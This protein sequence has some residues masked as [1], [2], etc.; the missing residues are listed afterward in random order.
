MN[1][2]T[3]V[4]L[5]EEGL[6]LLEYFKKWITPVLETISDFGLLELTGDTMDQGV[7]ITSV[8]KDAGINSVRL[9]INIRT[10]TL[11]LELQKLGQRVDISI[12]ISLIMDS[13]LI[14]ESYVYGRRSLELEIQT[15]NSRLKAEI[16]K[17]PLTIS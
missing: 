4:K 9:S 1:F 17:R 11:Y 16:R 8:Y 2:V 6:Y 13:L 15:L 7:L 3:S 12:F 5:L 10:G 14:N